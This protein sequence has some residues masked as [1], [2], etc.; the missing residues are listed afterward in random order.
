[1][2]KLSADDRLQRL[3]AVVPWVAARDGPRLDDVCARFDCREDEL[4]DDLQMLFL[5]GL[6]PY[7]PDMLI[8]VDIAD[9]RVWIRYADY[10]ARPLRLTPAEGL[11]LLAAGRALLVT[12][13]AEAGG[14][15][16]R[17]LS[18]LAAALGVGADEAVEIS[19]G[20]VPERVMAVLRSA[21]A[22]A[23]QV[24]IEYYAFGRD[25]WTRR[26][27]DP[28]SVFSAS[29]QWY[30]SAWCHLVEDER[31]FRVDRM[32][33]AELTG[34]AFEPPER[35]P[36]LAVYHPRPEDPRV[37][38]ELEPAAAWVVEQY[39]VEQVDDLGDGRLR[40]RLVAGQ[41]AWLERLLLRLGPTAR[42]VEGDPGAGRRRRG[43]PPE[44][45]RSPVAFHPCCAGRRLLRSP[46]RDRSTGIGPA[47]PRPAGSRPA[48][49]RP[50]DPEAGRRRRAKVSRSPQRNLV[51][52][53]LVVGGALL[54]AVVVKAF[55]IQAFY[56]PSPSMVPTLHVNDRVL[57]NKLSYDFHD[58]RRGDVI[59]FKSPQVVAEKDLIKR[60]IGLP[61]DT[62]E[63]RD[64]EIFV[65]DKVLDEPYLPSDVGTGPMEKV[66]VPPGH[67]WMMG[68]NRGNSSDS[69]VF[70]PIPESSIIGRAFVKVWPITAFGF[71]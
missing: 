15:L 40:V 16:E 69:R 63:T 64:G 70:G 23:R 35:P 29:G 6:H 30:L 34:T 36:E 68:D 52:W 21:V 49:R 42:M 66:T 56:I 22:G 32:R 25:E 27:V 28:Y 61:G 58:V 41:R 5:C 71:L 65:N 54:V 45:L 2:P 17:G 26:T 12:P 7:T 18:K 67:Y 43:P 50:A 62:V 53:V 9:G 4:V 57:V 14:P 11:A 39:P 60:V 8:D 24:E 55:L 44:P 37:V 13:G 20:A 33:S 19:L 48:S 1:M 31:L 38:L 51:E 59:V 47:D 10:F 3:L 46:G